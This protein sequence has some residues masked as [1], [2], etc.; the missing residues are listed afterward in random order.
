MAFVAYLALGSLVYASYGLTPEDLLLDLRDGQHRRPRPLEYLLAAVGWTV[1]LVG[2]P[3]AV[4]LRTF[5]T[6]RRRVAALVAKL[7]DDRHLAH[8]QVPRQR[9]PLK[10]L[11]IAAQMAQQRGTGGSMS[12][13]PQHPD[14]SAQPAPSAPL[15]WEHGYGPPMPHGAPPAQGFTSSP[16]LAT[17]GARLGA[18]VLDLIFWYITYGLLAIPVSMWISGDGGALAVAVLLVWLITSFVLYFPFCLWKYNQTLGKRICGV[19]I[20]PVGRDAQGVGFW[21]AVGRETFWLVGAFIPVLGLL[22]PLWCCWD[23]PYRQCLHDKVA[24]TMAVS[25]KTV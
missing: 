25:R 20:V 7:R 1:V 9:Q 6:I 16:G 3:L 13:H 11:S 19:R 10:S 18:R 24:D 8:V 15:Q 5:F 12:A 14:G 22:N 4:V 2:W 21:R 17:I 23:R